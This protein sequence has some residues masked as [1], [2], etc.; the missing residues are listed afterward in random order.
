MQIYIVE[1][2]MISFSHKTNR[3]FRNYCVEYVWIS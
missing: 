3:I 1:T 2:K